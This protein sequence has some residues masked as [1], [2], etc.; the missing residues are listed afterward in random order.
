[1]VW[2]DAV[3]KF[4]SGNSHLGMFGAIQCGLKKGSAS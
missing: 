4:L 1:M 2:N 3:S